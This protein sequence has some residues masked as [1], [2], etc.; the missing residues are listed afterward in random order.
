LSV[1]RACALLGIS[2]SWYYQRPAHRA[3]AEVALQLPPSGL[4]EIPGVEPMTRRQEVTRWGFCFCHL[5]FGAEEFERLSL[6]RFRQALGAEGVG[7]HGGHLHQIQRNPLFVE[8]N[9]GQVCRPA[10]VG[11]PDCAKVQTLVAD[12]V[13]AE[14]G[15]CLSHATYLGPPEDMDLILEAIAKVRANVG[16]LV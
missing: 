5:K 2:R 8:R 16:E 10:E 15:C 1:S 4:R 14:E 6:D 9:F 13:L 7:V 11:P 12:R 3:T